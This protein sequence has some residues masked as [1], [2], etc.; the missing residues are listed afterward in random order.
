[1]QKNSLFRLNNSVATELVRKI[2]AFYQIHLLLGAVA[3][4]TLP[5]AGA[6]WQRR[7]YFQRC[8]EGLLL[9]GLGERGKGERSETQRA[10]LAHGLNAKAGF[11][12]LFPVSA[13]FSQQSLCGTQQVEFA[14]GGARTTPQRHA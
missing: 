13:G 12:H 6:T 5:L 8:E 11:A 4:N 2:S 14:P 1:M 7:P 3:L 9:Q 10:L